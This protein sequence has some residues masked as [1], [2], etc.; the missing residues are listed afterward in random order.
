[1]TSARDAGSGRSA[2]LDALRAIAV[3]LV[4]GRH[5]PEVDPALPPAV[6]AVVVPWRHFGWI[7][8]DL[9]FV[10]SGFL[11]S[12]LLF[13]EH[14]RHGNLRVLRF[15]GRRGF[16]IYPAFYAL[17]LGSWFLAPPAIERINFL[18]EALFVQNYLGWVW[19]HTWSLAIEEHFYLGLVVIVGLMARVGRDAAEPF[20]RLPQICALGLALAFAIRLRTYSVYPRGTLL[21]P[22]HYRFDSL[23]FGTL[24]AYWWAYRRDEVI[25]YVRRRMTL[26]TISSLALLVPCVVLPLPNNFFVNTVGYTTNYLGFGGLLMA[27]VVRGRDTLAPGPTVRALARVGFYSY[28]T[29]LWHFPV[30]ALTVRYVP[31]QIGWTAMLVVYLIGSLVAGVLMA[32]LIELPF[33]R[34]RDRLLPSRTRVKAPPGQGSV[35]A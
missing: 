7:G 25:D 9:F 33:L 18:W 11:V 12:G 13:E 5:L 29:Y 16:K 20:R 6:R 30:L 1:M 19:S 32:K 21:L 28:S 27:A 4:L 26:L 23:L 17:L 22:T 10:L 14:R 31:R 34:L 24:L 2:T 35:A 3:L 15:L 8:V